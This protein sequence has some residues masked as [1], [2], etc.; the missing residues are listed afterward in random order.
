MKTSLFWIAVAGWI[1]GLMVHLLSLLSID[2]QDKVPYIWLLHLGIFIVWIPTASMLKKSGGLSSVGSSPWRLF[3]SL[4]QK[5]PDWV[6][7][8]AAGG[9]IYAV[10]NFILFIAMQDG[11]PAVS[12]GHY[13]L[14][15]HGTRIR[16]ITEQEYHHYRALTLRG[17]S[18]H[19]MA[20]YGMAAAFLYPFRKESQVA[21]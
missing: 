10:I 5:A 3:Y 18:G 20:F 4:K 13:Y 15:H 8:I 17:F 9:L 14:H 2:V 21:Q 1:L 7:A 12:N 16:D 11:T 19:W 6:A